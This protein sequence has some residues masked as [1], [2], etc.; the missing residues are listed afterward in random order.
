MA[1]LVVRLRCDAGEF[2]MRYGDTLLTEAADEIT[3]LRVEKKDLVKQRDD[4]VQD[5][6]AMIS[7]IERLKAELEAETKRR[8]DG[9]R[10]A[11]AEAAEEL[12]ECQAREAK[13]RET[14]DE[15]GNLNQEARFS[16]VITQIVRVALAL[17]TD[18]TA[19]KEA[20]EAALQASPE[21]DLLTRIGQ[22][23]SDVDYIGD[24]VEGI[25]QAKRETLLEAADWWDQD[26]NL[27]PR[28]HSRARK[29]FRRMAD[30]L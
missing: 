18:D 21:F 23:L 2:F 9:N 4:L 24:Y 15:I 29:E 26:D 6:L 5:N 10:I 19:L 14:L 17:P 1:D 11:S 13:L 20:I 7:E 27:I 22:Y 25:K 30:E 28:A 3:L 8:W 12:A 16:P